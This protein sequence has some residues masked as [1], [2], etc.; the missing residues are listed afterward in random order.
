MNKA[1]DLSK[2]ISYGLVWIE[3]KTLISFSMEENRIDVFSKHQEYAA[4][5]VIT[6]VFFSKIDRKFPTFTAERCSGF[7]GDQQHCAK[8]ELHH[9]RIE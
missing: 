5:I 6:F 1:L 9:P 8:V 7:L 2:E 4:L 3:S